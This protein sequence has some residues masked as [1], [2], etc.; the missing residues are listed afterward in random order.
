VRFSSIVQPQ[1][2]S[3]KQSASDAASVLSEA[4]CWRTFDYMGTPAGSACSQGVPAQ[5]SFQASNGPL[6]LRR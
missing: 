5:F 3:N 6:Y 2:L 1:Q 4:D